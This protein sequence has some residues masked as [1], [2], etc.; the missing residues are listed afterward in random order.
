MPDTIVLV[1]N[2]I[3]IYSKLVCSI[4]NEICAVLQWRE[5]TGKE[6]DN[7]KLGRPKNNTY[8]SAS[9]ISKPLRLS[10]LL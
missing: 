4:S 1:Y 3:A 7:Y 6:A 10:L 2:V 8:P 5:A 9:S